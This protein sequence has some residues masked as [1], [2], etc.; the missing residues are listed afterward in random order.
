MRTTQLEIKQVAHAIKVAGSPFRQLL[1]QTRQVMIGRDSQL[2][3]MLGGLLLNG[4]MLFKGGPGLEKATAMSILARG[5]NTKSRRLQ[6]TPDLLPTGLIEALIFRP[7]DGTPVARRGP[8]ISSIILTNEINRVVVKDPS[9]LLE[10]MQERQATVGRH[11]YR[12]DEPFL[13]LA[14]QAPNRQEGAYPLVEAQVDWLMLKLVADYPSKTEERAIVE[15]MP[16]TV[17][18]LDSDT[19]MTPGHVCEARKLVD[20]IHVDDKIKDYVVDPTFATRGPAAFGLPM[21]GWIMCGAFPCTT[22]AVT[23]APKA[24]RSRAVAAVSHHRT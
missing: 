20:Q 9:A 22:L 12:L 24:Q 18:D 15:R 2:Q 10:A 3:W 1:E 4:H 13:V 11:A 5:I 21:D 16:L 7:T 23:V 19:V 14:T 17:P 6:F 8:V